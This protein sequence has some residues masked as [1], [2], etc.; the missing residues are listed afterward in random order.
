MPSKYDNETIERA[1]RMYVERRAE[2]LG[3]TQSAAVGHVSTLTGIPADTVK[4]WARK[5]EIDAGARPGIT[6]DQVETVAAG[7]F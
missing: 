6:S 7:E 1:V 3:E 2:V 5:Y 4:V